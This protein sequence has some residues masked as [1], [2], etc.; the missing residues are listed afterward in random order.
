MILRRRRWV[1]LAV[2]SLTI[3]SALAAA[4]LEPAR[5]KVSP[6]I[7]PQP[8]AAALVG[9]LAGLLL[10]IVIVVV[11]EAVDWRLVDADDYASAF[12]SAVLARVPARKR[13]Q[14][15]RGAPNRARMRACV[16]LAALL[17]YTEVARDAGAIMIA[18]A[19][20]DDD[21]RGLALDLA[22][23]IAACGRRVVLIHADLGAERVGSPLDWGSGGVAAILAGHSTFARELVRTHLLA[24]P[25]GRS[26]H[27]SGPIVY[28][29]VLP[30]GPPVASPEVLLGQAA[31]RQIVEA[32]RARADT[33]LV[34]SAAVESASCSLPLARLCDGIL[35]VSRPRSLSQSRAARISG[36]IALSAP[37]LGIVLDEGGAGRSD[38]IA[39]MP[40]RP[41]VGHSHGSPNGNGN[42]TTNGAVSARPFG[43]GDV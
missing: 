3:G 13:G 38:T 36:L 33:V 20:A 27:D 41:L 4:E 25:E 42:G 31:L 21:V 23:A 19:T 29:E 5:R 14:R 12:G 2:F 8:V 37:L 26:E 28:Y 7:P 40:R 39:A 18:P 11:F 32:A 17:S 10:A 30:S 22:R 16:D 43:A 1:A 34:R 15:H 6:L 24:D 35:L 9:A